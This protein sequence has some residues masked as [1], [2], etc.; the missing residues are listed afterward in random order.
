ML[1]YVFE[2]LFRMYVCVLGVPY[3]YHC[4][5]TRKADEKLSFLNIYYG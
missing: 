1:F 5:L 4:V 3:K 2:G